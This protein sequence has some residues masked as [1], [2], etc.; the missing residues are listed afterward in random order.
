MYTAED[1]LSTMCREI[2]ELDI[3][4]DELGAQGDQE[5]GDSEEE[6]TGPEDSGE[7]DDEE[8][9][10]YDDLED[11]LLI[12]FVEGAAGFHL[13]PNGLDSDGGLEFYFDIV[14]SNGNRL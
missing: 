10:F 6:W 7:D 8:F 9:G 14:D 11:V 5:T 12:G 2:L 1:I 4:V 13:Q 3:Q